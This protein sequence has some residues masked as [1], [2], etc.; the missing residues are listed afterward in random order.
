MSI[1]K[2][3]CALIT[4]INYDYNIMNT[5]L[6]RANLLRL[7]WLTH[8]F[9]VI[10]NHNKGGHKYNHMNVTQSRLTGNYVFINGQTKSSFA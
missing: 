8:S 6:N 4:N 3:T 1:Q 5:M 2:S 10:I 9:N 7:T